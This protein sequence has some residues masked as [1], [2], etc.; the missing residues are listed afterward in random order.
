MIIS[1]VAKAYLSVVRDADIQSELHSHSCTPKRQDMPR[2]FILVTTVAWPKDTPVQEFSLSSVFHVFL[3][4]DGD[5]VRGIF[6][7]GLS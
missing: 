5:K 4:L 1:D 7:F 2:S 6:F 3:E